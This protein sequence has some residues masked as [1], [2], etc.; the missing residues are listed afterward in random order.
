[1]ENIDFNRLVIDTIKQS[2]SEYVSTGEVSAGLITET[3]KRLNFE[4]DRRKVSNEPTK[5]LEALRGDISW[6]KNDLFEL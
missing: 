5:E 6:L 1:M 2:F 3:Q 4:L